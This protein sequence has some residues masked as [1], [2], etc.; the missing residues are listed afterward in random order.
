MGS[1]FGEVKRFSYEDESSE[2]DDESI[3]S[4]EGDSESDDVLKQH[5]LRTRNDSLKSKYMAEDASSKKFLVSNFTKFTQHKMNMDEAIEVSCI[6]EKLPHSWK[7]FKMQDSDKPKCNNVAGPSVVNMVEH[8]NSYR[9]SHVYF[10]RMQ[11]MSKD[12]LISTF[13]M[14]TEKCKA[15]K[16][17]KKPFQNVKR[18][19]KV[20][21]PIHSDLCDLHAT[22]FLGNKKYFVTFINDASRDAI[23][24]ENRFSL[25]PRLSLGIPNGTEYI[26]GLVVPKKD[27]PKTF[28]EAMKFQD[29]A[30][31]K[32]AINDEMDS[33]MG[34]KTWVLADLPLGCKPLSC[35]W[36]FKRKLKYHKTADCYV[37]NLQSGYSLDGCEDN[38]LECKFDG[39]GKRDIICLYVDDM[40]IFGTNQV[41]AD[42]TKEFLSSRFFMKDMEEADI[43]LGIQIKH[44]SNGIAISHSYYIEKVLK[45]FNYFDC[46]PIGTPMDTSEKLMPNNGQAV[47]PL[48]YS[49]VIGC[50]MYAMTCTRLD[51]S[52][53]VG[54]LSRKDRK[55]LQRYLDVPTTSRRISLRS[56]D[57]FQGLTLKI[58]SSWHPFQSK[59]KSFMTMSLPSQDKPLTNRPVASSRTDEAG[60]KW[61]TFKPEKN[62]LGDTYN[63]SWKI[64]PYLRVSAALAFLVT[65]ASQSRQH[66]KSELV[67]TSLIHIE[68]RKSPT[69]SLF[70]VGSSRIFIFTVNT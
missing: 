29:V 43:I 54:K 38:F 49:R 26:G 45:K 52:F 4:D 28:D 37:I 33:I 7:D 10:K 11:D 70:N 5:M 16:I 51:I 36:I 48:E 62:N 55:T 59:S 25:V 64:H 24:D 23:F 50:L 63:P 41:Y 39:S 65:G 69:K 22:P 6:I 14:D 2:S 15:T 66:G 61:Y 30:F 13:D 21:E 9:L 12:G 20:L 18:E 47:S 42:L 53:G 67:D 68:L 35:K 27:D 46:T 31:W 17:T 19:T 3:Q 56:M 8:N 58:P 60:G 40:L 32:E 1:V 57:S 34:N 44:E